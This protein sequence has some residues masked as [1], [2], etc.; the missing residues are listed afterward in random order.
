VLG[1]DLSLYQGTPMGNPAAY[2]A[3]KGGLLQLTRWFSTVLAPIRVNAISPGGIERGQP[4]KFQQR[5]IQK[6]PLARMGS[7]S[8]MKGATLFLASDL[9]SYIT[10]QN[11]M[12]DG[13]FSVW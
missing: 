12:I 5:Y 7:D 2:S 10:G 3:S 6:V 4:E 13:G 11:I 1:P 8:D 9:S